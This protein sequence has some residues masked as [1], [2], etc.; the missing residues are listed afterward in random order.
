MQIFTIRC[1]S[2]VKSAVYLE[3][4]NIVICLKFAKNCL[5]LDNFKRMFPMHISKHE[6]RTRHEEKYNLSK[7]NGKRYGNSEIPNMLK[8]LNKQRKERKEREHEKS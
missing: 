6:M 7:S 5:M 2:A 4:Y 8:L 3:K 1:K